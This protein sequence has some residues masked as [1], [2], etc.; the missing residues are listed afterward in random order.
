MVKAKKTASGRLPAADLVT[1]GTA[2]ARAWPELQPLLRWFSEHKRDLPWRHTRDPYK[3]WLSEVMLQQTQAQTVIPY[4]QNFL[5]RFPTVREL[6]AAPQAEVLKAWEGLGYY[7]RARNLHAGAKYIIETCGGCFPESAEALLKVPG[8]GRYTAG[9]VAS[10]AFAQPVGA[11]DGNVLRVLCR[12]GNYPWQQGN[13]RDRRAGEALLDCLHQTGRY[14]AGPLNESL[15]ELGA[16]ICRPGAQANCPAC[17]LQ[18]V[19]KARLSGQV[20]ALPGPARRLAPLPVEQRSFLLLINQADQTWGFVQRP[21]SGLLAGFWEFPS[22]DGKVSQE[23]IDRYLEEQGYRVLHLDYL[24]QRRQIFTHL[25][26]DCDF[27]RAE[28]SLPLA[29]GPPAVTVSPP[30]EPPGLAALPDGQTARQLA[31]PGQAYTP[32]PRKPVP[33]APAPA[34]EQ[35]PGFS[36]PTSWLSPA[37]AAARFTFPRVL[38][39]F[40]PEPGAAAPLS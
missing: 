25:I 4:Y 12:L 8:I 20:Q 7:S 37:G 5:Q 26:W 10:L 36:Q 39:S 6:A 2:A 29:S 11:V 40:L 23:E 19:C 34:A 21:A 13:A 18:I 15:I 17:P 16:V 35:A 9:S 3:I 22:L 33:A 24:G 30:G 32:V 14:P 27:W 28:V 38:Q 1:W 31:E